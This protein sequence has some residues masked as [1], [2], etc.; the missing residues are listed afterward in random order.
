MEF[1]GRD[2]L[3]SLGAWFEAQEVSPPGTASFVACIFVARP[4]MCGPDGEPYEAWEGAPEVSGKVLFGANCFLLSGGIFVGLTSISRLPFSSPR[5]TPFPGPLRLKRPGLLASRTPSKAIDPL[6]SPL[7]PSLAP[8][9][10]TE[11]PGRLPGTLAG[12][13]ELPY[14]WLRGRGPGFMFL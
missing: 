3:Q 14:L 11:A 13:G 1:T 6:T 12:G 5:L 10:Q 7:P 8:H 4:S 9:P 2:M